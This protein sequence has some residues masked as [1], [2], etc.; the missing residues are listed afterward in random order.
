MS[1]QAMKNGA[2]NYYGSEF[3]GI[4]P[5][6]CELTNG[7]VYVAG[8]DNPVKATKLAGR[9]VPLREVDEVGELAQAWPGM[10][11]LDGLDRFSQHG[12]AGEA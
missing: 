3:G 8:D 6:V 4:V 11:D 2:Y 10:P 12:V 5:T 7:Y 1:N 9:F